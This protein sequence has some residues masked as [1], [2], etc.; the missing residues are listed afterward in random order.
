MDGAVLFA[1]SKLIISG[2]YF[3]KDDASVCY[4]LEMISYDHKRELLG[5]TELTRAVDD[6]TN[7]IYEKYGESSD[8]RELYIPEY[9]QNSHNEGS[10]EATAAR[11]LE[12]CN[13]PNHPYPR[14]N[15]HEEKNNEDE[16]GDVVMDDMEMDIDVE[17]YGDEG[18]NGGDEDTGGME[19][20]L[21]NFT[22]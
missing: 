5:D 11:F 21:A 18:D 15:E 17:G 7:A 14:S 20:Q 3:R 12:L 16:E 4:E 8:T 6:F 10:A 9:T 2:R 1:L 19:G 22:F 13:R